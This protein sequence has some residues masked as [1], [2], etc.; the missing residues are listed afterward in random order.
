MTD[1]REAV[2]ED[3]RAL[4]T[5][6]K[7]LLQSATTDPK[8][9]QRKEWIWRGLYA[10][11]GVVTTLAARRIATK[12]WGILTGEQPPVAGARR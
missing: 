1:K 11:F 3:L 5:D 12:A 9:R 8:E 4:A 10:V 7:S 2:T 6:F